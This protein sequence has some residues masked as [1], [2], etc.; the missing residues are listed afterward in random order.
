M[1]LFHTFRLQLVR[2]FL[3]PPDGIHLLFADADQFGALDSA[4]PAYQDLFCP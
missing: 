2:P 4:T 1:D 3:S